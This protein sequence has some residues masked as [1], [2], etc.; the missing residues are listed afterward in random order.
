MK[1]QLLLFFSYIIST[2][3]LA[4]SPSWVNPGATWYYKWTNYGFVGYNKIV[5]T[6]DTLIG[7]KTCEVLETTSYVYGA[8]GPG[9]G[10]VFFYSQVQPKHFTYAS[11]DTVFYQN[12]SGRF[13]V[14]YN[15]GAVI[16]D[17]WNL[18]IDSSE[19]TQCSRSVVKV[20]NTSSILIG[21][22]S[23]RVIYT[24]D[25]TNVTVGLNP[26][27]SPYQYA[28]LIEN[29]GSMVYLFPEYKNCNPSLSIDF[30]T[31]SFSCFYDGFNDYSVVSPGECANPFHV[32]ITEP[33]DD[34]DF[35]L[36]PNPA[37][38]NITISVNNSFGLKVSVY[39]VLGE[40]MFSEIPQNATFDLNIAGLNPG[41][42]FIS[43]DN[44]SGQKQVKRFVKN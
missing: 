37:T 23:H 28:K 1:K 41:I 38:D 17:S 27:D 6:H 21:S 39:N 31:Y 36:Y 19:F 30:S 7:T 25:S 40:L 42:Y 3:A 4:Q 15:F 34:K 18:G 26:F 5:Y 22:H 13:S 8:S 11:G 12:D 43:I 29:I 9:G 16:G 33:A 35:N 32:G 24:H 14:L 10:T 20:F 2:V 44:K